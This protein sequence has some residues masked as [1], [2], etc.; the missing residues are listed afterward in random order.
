MDFNSILIYMI[1]MVRYHHRNVGVWARRWGKKRG[2]LVFGYLAFLSRTRPIV[3]FSCSLSLFCCLLSSTKKVIMLEIVRHCRSCR[4][5]PILLLVSL[6]DCYL[7]SAMPWMM[8]CANTSRWFAW[9]LPSSST[10]TGITHDANVVID[11]SL[12]SAS[13]ASSFVWM[14]YVAGQ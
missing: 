6:Q 8:N 13:S 12:V 5:I 3:L 7:V 10:I 4:S 11:Y 2:A 9:Y 1:G 14:W